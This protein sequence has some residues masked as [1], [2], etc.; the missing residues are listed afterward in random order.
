M[1]RSLKPA[2]L[3]TATLLCVGCQSI[4]DRPVA[5]SPVTLG[6]DG[7]AGR[8]VV[9]YHPGGSSFPTKVATQL[10]EE[11]ARRGYIVDL[12]TADPTAVFDP[13]GYSAIVFGSPVYGAHVR[14]PIK[15]FVDTNAPFGMPVFAV[16]T[17]AFPQY[18]ATNDLPALTAFL[19]EHEVRLSGATKVA[20]GSDENELNEQV[21]AF[22]DLI[23]AKLE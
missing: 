5:S 10:G 19:N 4:W 17:G 2:A 20:S 12:M 16:L 1:F 9:V 18:Y 3:L 23:Q 7:T 11:A 8:I 14:P 6:T 22:V 13:S 21:F 15:D